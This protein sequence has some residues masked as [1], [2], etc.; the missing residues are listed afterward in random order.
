MEGPVVI[1]RRCQ[2]DFR[3][4]SNRSFRTGALLSISYFLPRR[5]A[6][7]HVSLAGVSIFVCVPLLASC[8]RGGS[9][10]MMHVLRVQVFE[11]WL[12]CHFITLMYFFHTFFLKAPR[13]TG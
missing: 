12:V 11:H 1:V 9:A 5:L 4:Q 13:S 6:E 10:C 8:S 7:K 3:F 2:K